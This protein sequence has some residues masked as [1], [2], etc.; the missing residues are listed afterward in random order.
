MGRAR[1]CGIAL[2]PLCLL[3]LVFSS[4][5]QSCGERKVFNSSVV[6]GTEVKYGYWPWHA[7][8][9]DKRS[10]SV[11]CGGTILNQ[12]TILT[13]AHC[14]E[15]SNGCIAVELVIVKVGRSRL[16]VADKRAQKHDALELIVYPGYNRD[17]NQHDIALIK[18]ATNIT[19]TD[20]IQPICLWNRGEDQNAIVGSWGTVIGFGINETNNPTKTLRETSI[21]VVATDICI[22]GKQDILATYITSDMFCA[23]NREEINACNGDSGGG[24]FLNY[25]DTWYIRGIVSFKQYRDETNTTD[26]TEYIVFTDVAKY[27]NWIKEHMGET[28]GQPTEN[29]NSKKIELLPMS[30]GANRYPYRSESLKPVLHGYP[31][32][33]LLEYTEDTDDNDEYT[34]HNETLCQ[35]TLISAL[36]LITSASCIHEIP[37]RYILSSVRLGEYDKDQTRDCAVVDSRMICSPPLQIR[38]IDT[39]ITHR[40]YNDQTLANDI[41]LIRLRYPAD[42]S[43]PNVKP[44]CLPVTSELRNQQST[45]YTLTTWVTCPCTSLLESSLREVIDLTE[46]QESYHNNSREITTSQLCMKQQHE[47]GP[48]C[49]LPVTGSTL[50]LVQELNGKSRYVLHG[51]LSYGPDDCDFDFPDVYTSIASYVD[52]ILENI[53]E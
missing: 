16:R 35:A 33:A 32:V 22:E 45:H 18:L 7:A 21:P 46:C 42:I 41:A 49:K 51:F 15:T 23:G 37:N 27:L 6:N 17:T 13:A 48:D 36:Y 4:L 34:S 40:N 44:I 14:L 9:Y 3:P 8:I 30:C 31:W 28:D 10:G 2:I 52:W 47:I 1:C 38:E 43:Q 12:N 5:A 29:D 50:Q 19:Y 11:T 20:Y 39:V 53:E 26:T 24:F 25:T